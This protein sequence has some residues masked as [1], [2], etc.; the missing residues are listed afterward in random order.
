MWGQK[1][2]GGSRPGHQN[3]TDTQGRGCAA[4]GLVELWCQ[5][6]PCS[7]LLCSS[8]DDVIGKVCITRDMLLD[9]PKGRGPVAG[10]APLRSHLPP[11]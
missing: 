9:N 3:A 11:P 6:M 4:W 5:P 7:W 10:R 8:R 2:C 1:H